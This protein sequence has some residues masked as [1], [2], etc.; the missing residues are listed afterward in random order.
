MGEMIPHI[1]SSTAGRST[2][3]GLF[4]S[5]HWAG[6]AGPGFWRGICHL[7]Q[8]FWCDKTLS[9]YVQLVVNI[10]LSAGSA[11]L[12]NWIE[13]LILSRGD[14]Y[15]STQSS[16]PRHGWLHGS[17]YRTGFSCGCRYGPSHLRQTTKLS[18]FHI[19]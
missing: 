4:Q 17:G 1:Y 3:T 12:N 19:K 16:N 13:S 10:R 9:F 6:P 11:T 14:I 18:F 5:S 7:S 15:C 8:A 2:Q